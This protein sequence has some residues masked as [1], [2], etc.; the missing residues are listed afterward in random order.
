MEL[1][2][3]EGEGPAW[4]IKDYKFLIPKKNGGKLTL[5]WDKFRKMTVNTFISINIIDND[6]II[7]LRDSKL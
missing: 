2:M 4:N 1:V 7:T 6:Y 3:V 5:K